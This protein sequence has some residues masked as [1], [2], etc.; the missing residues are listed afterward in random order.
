[1]MQPPRSMGYDLSNAVLLMDAYG[2]GCVLPMQNCSAPEVCGYV[3][4]LSFF[5]NFTWRGQQLHETL[6]SH[7]RGTS[8]QN[9]VE[10]GDYVISI[11]DNKSGFTPFHFHSQSQIPVGWN[12]LVKEGA[13]IV[14]SMVMKKVQLQSM[15][16]RLQRTTCPVCYTTKLGVMPDDGWFKWY[17][18]FISLARLFDDMVGCSRH[19]KKCFN[20]ADMAAEQRLP[21]ITGESME[22][23]RNLY[24][25]PVRQVN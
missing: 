1:M 12:S 7:F 10:R 9:L 2:E 23:F 11:K 6:L 3:V 21:P 18:T 13:V 5:Y 22:H 8:G 20:C 17:A 24:L 25:L 14:M 15:A 19:C 16:G 4:C